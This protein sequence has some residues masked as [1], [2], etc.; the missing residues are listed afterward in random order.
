MVNKKINVLHITFDMRI[1]GTE[2][3]IKNLVEATDENQFNTSI[4]C[5]EK[6]LGPF[7]KLLVDR[8]IQID[9]FQRK[10]GFDRSLI[11]QIR[12]YIK[13][14]HVDIIHCHQYTP[15]VYG[16]FA[17]LFLNVKVVFTEHGRFYPDSG[18]WKR[19][20]INPTLSFFTDKITSISEA[21]KQ[22]L[23]E[24]EYLSSKKIDVVYNGISPKKPQTEVVSSLREQY[25]F[26][27]SDIVFG[28]VARLDP[29]KN[30]T[31]L[32]N[33][34]HQVLIQTPNCKLLIVG[35]GDERENLELLTEK[36]NI[37]ESV[38]FTGYITQPVNYMALMDV[39]LLPSLSEGTS[40]TLLEA[41]SLSK[42]CIVTS[43]GGNPEVIQD[44][45]NGIVIG[46]QELEQLMSAMVKLAENKVER[47]TFGQNGENLFNRKF[48]VKSMAAN[49]QK[50]YKK[51]A[52]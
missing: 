19:R 22:A 46:N 40:M 52:G 48:L 27:Q 5:I 24:F 44:Q 42:P 17:S 4:L 26:K 51:I 12:Q 25:N 6:P 29:I 13:K 9:L 20:F 18:S 32:I 16:V 39:F 34:F 38:I 1:G 49:Y 30:Q 43:V 33:A 2:Q 15:W 10:N 23:V 35:D 50:I 31:L 37:A 41:M 21:T 11:G 47:E 14:H 28:T 36:L 7:G 3:V 8:G 45:H